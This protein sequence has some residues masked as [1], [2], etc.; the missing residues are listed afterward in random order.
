MAEGTAE[1]TEQSKNDQTNTNLTTGN[2][3]APVTTPVA[4]PVTQ[5]IT[6]PTS[7]PVQTE[8]DSDQKEKDLDDRIKRERLD[9][10]RSAQ[11]QVAKAA[12]FNSVE[13]MQD[14]AR[15][16]KELLDSQKSELQLKAE[17]VTALETENAELRS[18][19]SE[20]VIKMDLMDYLS[21]KHKDYVGRQEWILPKAR[22][23]VSRTKGSEEERA[24]AIK[25]VVE[26]FVKDN[27]I[28]P[29]ES[30]ETRQTV[31]TPGSGPAPQRTASGTPAPA[32][33]SASA[34]ANQYVH[35]AK[36]I[37]GMRRG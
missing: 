6:Q 22:E 33:S 7:L 17:R 25:N 27:P 13:E 36:S 32:S 20:L 18:K 21:K 31:R 35:T 10:A 30:N 34:I 3:P 15:K 19:Y 28:Q 29:Q 26:S 24:L 1:N 37:S 5:P 9:A 12:G 11:E 23:E 2:G 14:A 8:D 16:H 4:Q